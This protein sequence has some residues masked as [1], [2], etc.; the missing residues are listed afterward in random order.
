MAPHTAEH[1]PARSDSVEFCGF[2]SSLYLILIK[3]FFKHFWSV[4]LSWYLLFVLPLGVNE[5]SRKNNH[6]TSADHK[7]LRTADH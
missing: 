7:L 6:V 3:V 2:S 5:A 1:L 4:R